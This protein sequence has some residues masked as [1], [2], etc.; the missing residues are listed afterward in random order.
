MSN[1]VSGP[2]AQ[3]RQEQEEAWAERLDK[4]RLVW[5]QV[6][7]CKAPQAARGIALGIGHGKP[8]SIEVLPPRSWQEREEAERIWKLKVQ[9]AQAGAAA[10][11]A[12][13]ERKSIIV[14]EQAAAADAAK[15]ERTCQR[16]GA[17]QGCFV[18]PDT[19]AP[20][21]GIDKSFAHCCK[22]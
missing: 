10:A 17:L 14:T 5:Q 19:C 13:L 3:E 9:E 4:A 6:S 11:A 2:A 8:V 15:E 18:Y 20:L 12:A 21:S 22:V 7:R 16:Q 1:S